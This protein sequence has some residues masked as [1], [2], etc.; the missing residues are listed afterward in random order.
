M[1]TQQVA[2]R[3]YE[4]AQQGQFEQILGE[5]FSQDAKSVEPAGA[6]MPSVEGLEAII[7]KGKSWN[8]AVE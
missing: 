4:L 1:T 3:F 2:D 5:L 7:E 8:E 6:D